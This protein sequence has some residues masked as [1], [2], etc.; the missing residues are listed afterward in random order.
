MNVSEMAYSQLVYDFVGGL[1]D[2]DGSYT[3]GNGRVLFLP[4]VNSDKSTIGRLK[5]NLNKEVVL[6]NV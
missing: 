1:L 2:R 6:T 3:V 4:S 5:V